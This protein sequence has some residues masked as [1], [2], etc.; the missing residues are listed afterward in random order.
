MTNCVLCQKD[1]IGIGANPD[2]VSLF[3]VCCDLVTNKK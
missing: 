1:F 3:G 2:P